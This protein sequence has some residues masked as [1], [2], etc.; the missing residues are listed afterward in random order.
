LTQTIEAG[1]HWIL[2]GQVVEGEHREGVSPMI[3]SRRGYFGL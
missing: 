2:L 1:D 3:F